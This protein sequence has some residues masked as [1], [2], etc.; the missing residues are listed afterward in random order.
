[1]SD[2]KLTHL[3]IRDTAL[4]FGLA[5]NVTNPVPVAARTA[6][7]IRI[8][9]LLDH[10]RHPANRLLKP[11]TEVALGPLQFFP[12]E[13]HLKKDG[14]VVRL[15]EKERDILL[16]LLEAD[17]KVIT[18]EN[19]LHTVWGYASDV[20]THTLETHIYRLRHKIESH[21]G[22]PE[23]LITAGEGYRLSL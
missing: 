2:S 23:L 15:T 14:E 6:A 12:A 8:G 18:R 21:P 1:M 4:R 22:K 11:G 7:G 19:L 17:G 5:W 20:E 16:I 10:L 9:A 3:I 13:N